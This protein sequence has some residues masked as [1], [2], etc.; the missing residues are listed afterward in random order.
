[1]WADSN[2]ALLQAGMGI[3]N[4]T[5]GPDYITIQDFRMTK[6]SGTSSCFTFTG[7]IAGNDAQKHIDYVIVRRNYVYKTNGAMFYY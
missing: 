3:G 5:A 2:G 4:A 1:V 6:Q 7:Y